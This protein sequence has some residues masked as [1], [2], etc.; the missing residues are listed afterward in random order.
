MMLYAFGFMCTTG[1]HQPALD[2]DRFH[3]GVL[4]S[5]QRNDLLQVPKD[6]IKLAGVKGFTKKGVEL[7]DGSAVECD[8]VIFATG[9]GTGIDDIELEKDGAPH[10]LGVGSLF[11]HLFVPRFPVLANASSLFT[12]FG[13]VRGCN[14]AELA[15]YHTC[16]RG[17]LTEESMERTARRYLA[18]NDPRAWLAFGTT[19]H[20]LPTVQNWLFL[21]LDLIF[22]GIIPIE[23]LVLHMLQMFSTA[24][25]TPL[26]LK[27]VPRQAPCGGA[28]E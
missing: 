25:Q 10:E 16:V 12:T 21:Y 6:R 28:T 7:S 5:K 8:V 3:F 4:C 22:G 26:D 18:V 19:K 9:N 20:P 14:V 13:P 23:S 11:N 17:Q 2:A 1:D 15:V 27:L 24:D